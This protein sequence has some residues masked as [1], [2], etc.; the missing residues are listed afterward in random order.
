MK[1]LIIAMAISVFIVIYEIQKYFNNHDDD[2]KGPIP[3]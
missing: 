2:Y 3:Q 1:L